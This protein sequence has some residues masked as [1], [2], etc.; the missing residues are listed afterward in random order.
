MHHFIADVP[1]DERTVLRVAWDWVL[2]PMA[3]H[4]PVAAW[5]VDDTAFP[6]KGSTR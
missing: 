1:W 5:I 2:D 6:K 4:G 3:R